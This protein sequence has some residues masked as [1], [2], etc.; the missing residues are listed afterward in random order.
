MA[1]AIARLRTREKYPPARFA[2]RV[3]SRKKITPL[4]RFFVA[5]FFV[6]SLAR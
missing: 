1:R 6:A 5:H 3:L 2:A 4:A